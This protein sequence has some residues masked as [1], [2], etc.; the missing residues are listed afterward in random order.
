M[1]SSQNFDFATEIAQRNF[2]G[3]LQNLGSNQ[4]PMPAAKG[5]NNLQCLLGLQFT[6]SCTKTLDLAGH[7]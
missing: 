5:H 3:A 2:T 1:D 6:W 7:A 4:A